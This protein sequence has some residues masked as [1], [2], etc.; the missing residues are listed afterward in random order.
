MA[1]KKVV[2][3]GSSVM[4]SQL[5]DLWRQFADGSLTGKHLQAFLEHRNPFSEDQFFT[6]TDDGTKTTSELVQDLRDLD[7]TVSVYREEHLDTDFPAPR[8]ATT[9]R[10]KRSVEAD[11]EHAGK[12]ANDA[13]K[14]GLEGITLRERLIMEKQY[15]QETGK[16][17]DP[18]TWTICSGSR[19]PGGR[20]PYVGWDPVVRKLEVGWSILGDRSSN[21]RV[22]SAVC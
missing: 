3:E 22:R 21:V 9:R 20:V 8:K 17:L 12:S 14:E 5:K 2:V 7:I 19:C 13:D 15:F 18:E 6:I 4:A 16:H 1:T 10:F 11:P